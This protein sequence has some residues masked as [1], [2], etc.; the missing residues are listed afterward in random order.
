MSSVVTSV[1]TFKIESNFDEWEAII[2]SSEA[3]KRHSKFDIKPLFRDISK[4]DSQKVIVINQAPEGNI[5]KFIEA[6][7]DW[8]ATH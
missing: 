7:S 8:M 5:Q 2:D 4:E 3:D 6:N 1:F